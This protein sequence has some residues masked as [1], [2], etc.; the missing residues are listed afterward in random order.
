[1]PLS[2][3]PIKKLTNLIKDSFRV[4]RNQRPLYVDLG[5]SLERIA[6]AQHQV[7]FG[8]RGSGKSCLLVHYLNTTADSRI[9]PIYVLADEFKKLTYPNILIRLLVEILESIPVRW[10]VFKKLL[11]RPAPTRIAAEE[12]RKLLDV[13]DESEVVEDRQHR[14]ADTASVNVSAQGVGQAAIGS[15]TDQ[16]HTRSSRFKERKIDTL[17]RHLRDYKNAIISAVTT[18]N[19]LIDFNFILR[20]PANSLLGLPCKLHSC[21]TYWPLPSALLPLLSTPSSATFSGLAFTLPSSLNFVGVVLT[22]K[23]MRLFLARFS[24]VSLCT[25]GLYSP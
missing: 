14:T 18:I 23:T 20:S 2:D 13:A 4:R 25:R 16:A 5:G 9:L 7:I 6:A 8:R 1:M 19:A 10:A 22:K 15:T 3:P 24:G 21:K 12:L 11:R 17:E